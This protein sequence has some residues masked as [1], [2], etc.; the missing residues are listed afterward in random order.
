MNP[1]SN[2]WIPDEIKRAKDENFKLYSLNS[3]MFI[4]RKIYYIKTLKR[5]SGK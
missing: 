3:K 5:Y 1:K 4:Y 2:L